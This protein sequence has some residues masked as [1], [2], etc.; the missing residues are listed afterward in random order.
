MLQIRIN[1]ILACLLAFETEDVVWFGTSHVESSVE[2]LMELAVPH[3]FGCQTSEKGLFRKQYADGILGLAM[4][5]TS[6]VQAMHH[7]GA[8]PRNAFSLCFTRTGGH[9]SLGGS[10]TSCHLEPMNFSNISQA[11]GWYSLQVEQ[12]TVGNISIVNSRTLQSFASGKGTILD[13]GTTDT[14]FPKAVA[15]KLAT[16]WKDWSGLDYSNEPRFYSANEFE[17]LPNIKITFEG[18]VTLTIAPESYM[19]GV[20]VSTEGSNAR[21]WWRGKH[22]LTNRLYADE[23][24]G[25]VL[26]A[27]AMFGY[28]ILFDTQ[29]HRVGLARADCSA[30]VTSDESAT[31]K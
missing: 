8:I 28:D 17:R 26:G 15:P 25:A 11:H 14:F 13:S 27:N 12:V 29:G 5:E 4:H 30:I 18:N 7:A 19:E 9:L 1:L 24:R 21:P 2:D 31:A 23:P 20:P 16:V 3:T 6:I 10:D 22:Q